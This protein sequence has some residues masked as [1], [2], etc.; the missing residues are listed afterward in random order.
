MYDYPDRRAAWRRRGAKGPVPFPWHP[1]VKRMLSEFLEQ[2]NVPLL[3]QS[4]KEGMQRS[5]P[6]AVYI[7]RKECKAPSQNS[8]RRSNSSRCPVGRIQQS[9]GVAAQ[10]CVLMAH[11]EP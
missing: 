1:K 2:K 10:L 7:P 4:L 11:G 6:D 3:L 8:T 5:S 9:P